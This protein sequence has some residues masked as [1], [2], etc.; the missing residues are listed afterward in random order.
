[1]E[2]DSRMTKYLRV[3][4]ALAAFGMQF[5]YGAD[6][7]SS[8]GVKTIYAPLEGSHE[9]FVQQS[10][11][12]KQLGEMRGRADSGDLMGMLELSQSLMMDKNVTL[13]DL[14]AIDQLLSRASKLPG[15]QSNV[16][17]LRASYLGLKGK[18]EGKG[19]YTVKYVDLNKFSAATLMVTEKNL[20]MPRL[21]IDYGLYSE[22][23]DVLGTTQCVKDGV[24]DQSCMA[25]RLEGMQADLLA[26]KKYRMSHGWTFKDVTPESLIDAKSKQCPDATQC[27][28]PATYTMN[29]TLSGW[30]KDESQ[31]SKDYADMVNYYWTK[32][33]MVVVKKRQA[34]KAAEDAYEQK[35]ANNPFYIRAELRKK[36]LAMDT[37]YAKMAMNS[38]DGIK[39]TA[40]CSLLTNGLYEVLLGNM[41]DE[42]KLKFYDT[43]LNQLIR[44]SCLIEQ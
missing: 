29:R 39:K 4:A 31:L 20:P 32:P 12:E 14:P 11:S 26:L 28:S 9:E 25:K 35:Q 10:P 41:I 19:D 34:D 13:Q 16:A 37:P 8:D 2:G 33:L 30:T 40:N 27:I 6:V 15:S 38:D 17:D 7:T 42:A 22:L 1:M 3:L 23:N 24:R 43:M 21:S 5:S 18:L 44:T 36:A